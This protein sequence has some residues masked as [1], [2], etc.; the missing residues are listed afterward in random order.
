M[1]ARPRIL[2]GPLVRHVSERRAVIWVEVSREGRLRL[3]VL[4]FGR[5]VGS[6]SVFT[7][8]FSLY[9]YALI[10]L[11]GL[12]SGTEYG[13]R[14]HFE[15]PEVGPPVQIWP[16]PTVRMPPSG[17]RTLPR[18]GHALSVSYLSCR[19]GRPSL[20]ALLRKHK[21]K[22]DP[23][24]EA[25]NEGDG[26]D[27]LDA[28][29]RRMLKDHRLR[30]LRWPDMLLMMGDQIYSDSLSN[31]MKA[32]VKPRRDRLLARLSAA[33]YSFDKKTRDGLYG[34]LLSF[35][36]YRI[37]YHE[38][39]RSPH[40]R[41]ALSCV[42]SLMIFD[43]HE[44]LDDWNISRPWLTQQGQLPWWQSQFTG[45]LAAY[46]IYQGAG[47]L[48]P[49]TWRRE[50]KMRDF[51]AARTRQRPAGS[52]NIRSQML[53]IAAGRRQRF[54]FVLDA[55]P[56]QLVVTDCRSRRELDPRDRRLMDAEEW[57]WFERQCLGSHHPHLVLA[58]SIPV[59]LPAMI[60][61]IFS[62]VE[63]IA[64]SPTVLGLAGEWARQK[65]DVE[66]WAAFPNSFRQIAT[67]LRKL[68]GEGGHRSKRTVLILSGDVHF[69]YNMEV[70]TPTI[71]PT[72]SRILQLVS[73]PARKSLDSADAKVIQAMQ[74]LS[75]FPATQDGVS[76][77]PLRTPNG[78]LWFGNTISTVTV[79]HAGVSV[80]SER[81]VAARVR[82]DRNGRI[83][84]RDELRLAPLTRFTAPVR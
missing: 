40:V 57:A 38:A 12:R 42:P 49:R 1:T 27:A 32:W 55:G 39:W 67:L 44:I 43:D 75:S 59:F 77:K 53:Q 66:H 30:R 62:G 74:S 2:L 71:F 28:F 10:P 82:R 84:T 76:W 63:G 60:H 46:W 31:D 26:A 51:E 22:D 56:T 36:E 54:G 16:E 52:L 73:S 20:E 15:E 17:F 58:V 8:R 4:R 68:T 23:L 64:N 14:I 9:H 18:Y 45:A 65:V 81:A 19:T 83:E 29:S 47:N 21:H 79:G 13:Y 37:A 41:W 50:P 70:S 33:G 35:E 34:Q 61:A 72:G 11:E 5:V 7:V 24:T 48:S 69:T 3:E 25:I 80:V 6:V 78:W